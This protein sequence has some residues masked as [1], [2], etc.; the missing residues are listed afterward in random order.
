MEIQSA[1]LSEK[2]ALGQGYNV[3]Q[4]EFCGQC[5][6][7][8]VEFAGNQQSQLSFQRSM[9]EEAAASELGFQFG[10]KVR[11]GLF[12]GSLAAQFATSSTSS[13][14]SDVTVYSHIISFKNAKLRFPGVATGLTPEGVAAKG[15]SEGTMVGD[16]WPITCGHEVVQQITL[17]AKLMISVSV[18][19]ATREDK[20]SFS[21]DVDFQGPPIEV[22][23]AL[24]MASQRYGKT[25][26]LTLNAFQLGGDVRKLADVFGTDPGGAPILVASLD[27]P[28][29]VLAALNAAV[30]YGREDF[31]NQVDPEAALGS[32]NGPAQLSYLT[33]PWAELGLFAPPPII[34]DGVLLARRTLS[35]EFEKNARYRQRLSRI[36]NGPVRLSPRQLERFKQ[37]QNV[38]ARN[39]SLIQEA[40]VV[41]YTDF[42]AAAAKVASTLEQLEDFTP[43]EF[44]V[45]PESFAQWWDMRNLPGTLITDR[46]ALEDIA[47]PLIPQF[48]D[49]NAVEDQGLALQQQLAQMEGDF[50]TAVSMQMFNSRAWS[51]MTESKITA[52][53]L[54]CVGDV[55]PVDL[56]PLRFTPRLRT[57]SARPCHRLELD[58]GPVA[59]L[60]DLTELKIGNAQI[61]DVEALATL[62]NLVELRLDGPIAD[63]TPLAGLAE[64]RELTISDSE[65]T[66][67]T[68]LAGLTEL[69]TVLLTGAPVLSVE[70]LLALTRL[71]SFDVGTAKEPVDQMEALMA[72]PRFRTFCAGAP[73][74]AMK[75]T[76]STGIIETIPAAEVVWT[77]R[78]ATNVFDTTSTDPATGTQTA[79]IGAFTGAQVGDD[80]QA[81]TFL[82]RREGTT[83]AYFGMLSEDGLSASGMVTRDNVFVGNCEIR[84]P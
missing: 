77:R 25:A 32:P 65:V 21:A 52:L 36:L 20:Q 63:L 5:V 73:Q 83:F 57:L 49:F 26:S 58:L 61:Q 81:I 56:R 31:A 70:P 66:D 19:F 3:E 79:G 7:G 13:E 22:E 17:G 68:P 41:C 39:L 82:H 33:G 62:M 2:A 24:Q 48:I 45:Q 46:Q 84:L 55:D 15:S 23:A 16:N 60:P 14:Y 75:E 40:A 1:S 43:E 54:T 6:R 47:A 80:L 67:L 42:L 76:P 10:T 53:S 38:V 29:A 69:R 50:P 18:E 4:E 8:D 78:G 28:G 74:V 51:V 44:D 12:S 34:S 9:S 30:R 27:N 72:L 35:E 11:Y 59:D 71:Q 37:I 64:L